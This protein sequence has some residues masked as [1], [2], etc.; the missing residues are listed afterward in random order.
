MVTQVHGL[1][2]SA[3][4]TQPKFLA[5][6]FGQALMGLSQVFGKSASR[7]KFPLLSLHPLPFSK[8]FPK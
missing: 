3:W 1:L 8:S 6:G 4:G 5:P 7:S 2:P